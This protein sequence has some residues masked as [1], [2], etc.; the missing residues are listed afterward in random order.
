MEFI[1]LARKRYSVRGFSNQEIAIKDLESLAVAANLTPS[2]CNSQP[3]KVIIVKRADLV[4][5]V[6]TTAMATG[7]NAF[8]Q[9]AQAFV[10]ILE[11]KVKLMRRIGSMIDSQ[12]FAK[13][14]LGACMYGITLQAASIGLGS[15]IIGMFDREKIAEALDLDANVSIFGLVALGYPLNQDVPTKLR[16]SLADTASIK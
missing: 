15:C 10:V 8:L 1:E 6:A 12:S 9:S 4:A 11:V 14:D 7:M 13:Q 2:A 3:W 5:K 16:K